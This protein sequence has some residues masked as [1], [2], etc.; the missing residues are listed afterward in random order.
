[1]LCIVY[2][3]LYVFTLHAFILH[4][5]AFIFHFSFKYALCVSYHTQHTQYT[6]FSPTPA[7]CLGYYI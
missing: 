3:M 7:S 5:Y 6:F 4:L 2:A 1:M